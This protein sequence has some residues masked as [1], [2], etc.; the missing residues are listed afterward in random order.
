MN[1]HIPKWVPTLGIGV[2]MDFQIFKMWMQ[3]SK[4]IGL[5]IFLYHWK[6]LRTK[7]SKMGLHD[8]F[9]HF[10]HKL[11]PKESSKVKLSI[12]LPTIKSQKSSGFSFVQV[13]C[14]IPLESFRW[15]LQFF[16]KPHLNRR[17]AHKIMGPPKSQESQLWEFR[18]SHFGVWKQ[19]DIWVLVSWP[20]TKYTIKGKVVASFKSGPWW[21]LW[22]RVCPWLI[23][24]PKGFSYAL[25]NLLFGL[26]RSVWISELLV[27]LPSPIL[28]L[29]HAPLP[30]KWCEPGSAPQLLLSLS[31]FLDSQ[32]SPSR[33]LGVCHNPTTTWPKIIMVLLCVPWWS[34]KNLGVLK[35]IRAHLPPH[36]GLFLPF[37]PLRFCLFQGA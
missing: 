17:S 10:K 18:D 9:G 6:S 30:P 15:G 21:V 2:P 31:S 23:H 34:W 27:N 35:N 3:G 12:W 4:L 5:N 20:C 14:D 25:T 11:W 29:Q 33:S 36:F 22:V 8:P 24:A 1:L 37:M 16:L 13:T 26:C 19:N 32:L 7:M 28:K